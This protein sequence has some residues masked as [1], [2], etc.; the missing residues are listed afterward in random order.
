MEVEIIKKGISGFNGEAW[1]LKSGK[2]YFVASGL[3]MAFD[4]GLS[5]VL[6]FESDKFGIVDCWKD[7]AGGSGMSH[8]EAIEDLKSKLI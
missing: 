1:L 8:E 5:E 3:S 7:V 2:K 6:I 4:T